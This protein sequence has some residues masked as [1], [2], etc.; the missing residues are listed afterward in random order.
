MRDL[1]S[2]LGRHGSAVAA[3]LFVSRIA[4]FLALPFL[5]E[6]MVETDYAS[7]DNLHLIGQLVA[8]VALQG[9]P[10]AMFREYAFASSSPAD[11]RSIIVTGFRYVAVSTVLACFVAGMFSRPIAEG[12]TNNLA[13]WKLF[14]LILFTHLLLNLRNLCGQVLR[15]EYRTKEF[16]LIYSGEGLLCLALNLY[17]VVHLKQGV[18]GLVYSNLLGAVA[19]TMLGLFFVP[20]ALSPGVDRARL[21]RMIQFGRPL[22]LPTLTLFLLDSAD[23]ALFRLMLGE[24]GLEL[25]GIYGRAMTFASMLNAL[26]L[27]PLNTFWPTVYYDLAKR[28]TGA[29][30]IGR[31]GSW[32]FAIGCLLATGL[33]VIAEPLVS[34]MTDRRYHE[35]HTVV[36]L[37]AF[38]FVMLGASE[39]TKVGMFIAARTKWMPWLVAVALLVN[40]G[41]NAWLIPRVGLLGAGWA[42]LVAYFALAVVAGLVGQRLFAI[43]YEWSRL[44]RVLLAVGVCFALGAWLPVDVS[45]SVADRI[46][47]ILLRGTTVV[48]AFPAVLLATRFFTRGELDFLRRLAPPS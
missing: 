19:A 10:S 31:C 5:T 27:M 4:S 8:L 22:I 38:A 35:A 14:P 40:I 2:K 18:A 47:N 6:A 23:R 32:Y 37:L 21:S 11:K 7:H 36:P 41:V 24:P 13:F 29:H 17:F 3:A 39:I 9:I 44:A 20:E 26:L 45:S 46:G 25:S 1:A 15:A 30:D 16:V 42:A 43:R 12:A 34:L 28:P 33:S 48:I